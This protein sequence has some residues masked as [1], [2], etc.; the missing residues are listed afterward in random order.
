MIILL[1][2]ASSNHYNK[3]FFHDFIGP[4]WH[5]EDENNPNQE[6][7]LLDL[8][9]QTI[10]CANSHGNSVNTGPT[11]NDHCHQTPND[12]A[13]PVPDHIVNTA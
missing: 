5:Q 10:L 12:T 13:V 2:N 9:M 11:T 1:K 7:N 3:K 4:T 8:S 6:N